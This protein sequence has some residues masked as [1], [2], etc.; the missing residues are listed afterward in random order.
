MQQESADRNMDWR[1]PA[2]QFDRRRIDADLL[3][4]FAKRRGL[5]RLARIDASSGN[6]T[7]PV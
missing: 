7:C 3:G 5:E 2:E 4:C 1:E 6:D